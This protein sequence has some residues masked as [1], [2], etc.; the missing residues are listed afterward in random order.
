[1]LLRRQKT[2]TCL[3][4]IVTAK[5]FQ[6]YLFLLFTVT[7]GRFIIAIITILL[8]LQNSDYFTTFANFINYMSKVS[9]TFLSKLEWKSV[10]KIKC[11]TAFL[12][13]FYPLNI[14]CSLGSD[15][16]IQICIYY[17]CNTHNHVFLDK[18]M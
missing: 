3:L 13:P 1:M 16:H 18:E 10:R 15:D 4:Y 14:I 5:N 17:L 12:S 7:N 8:Y 2:A 11:I 9:N 6:T